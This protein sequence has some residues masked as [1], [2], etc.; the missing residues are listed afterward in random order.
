MGRKR[1]NEGMKIISFVII[2]IFCQLFIGTEW[3]AAEVHHQLQVELDLK[4]GLLKGTD[5]ISLDSSSPATLNLLLSPEAR[6]ISI[7]SAGEEIELSRQGE[8][9]VVKQPG[10]PLKISWI[11]P[12]QKKI[13]AEPTH[14][15]DP[16]YGVVA[17]ISP[18]GSYLAEGSNWYPRVEGQNATHDISVTLPPGHWAV[19]AGQLADREE[20]E[21]ENSIRWTADYPLS[22]LSLASGPWVV[23]EDS[24]NKI[25]VYAF[26]YKDSSAF[27]DTYITSAKE[28]LNLYETLFGPYPFHKFAVVENFLP[29][30]YGFP[31]WT[32]LGSR[33]VKLPFIVQTSLGHEVA[34][35]WWGN[36]VHTDPRYGNW[37]EGLTTYVADYLYKE[38]ES[39]A[40]AKDY[41]LKIL[42]EYS[43]LVPPQGMPLRSFQ[44]RSDKASQAIGYGKSAMV[45]HLI[46]QRIGDQAFWA[47]LR[48]TAHTYM[49]KQ[50][51]WNQLIAEFSHQANSNL[52]PV[53]TPWLDRGDIPRLYLAA[54]KS[55]RLDQGWQI[56]GHLNQT[57]LPYPLL[58][59]VV[60]NTVEGEVKRQL[61]SDQSRTEFRFDL[62]SRPLSL[63]IDPDCQ[64]L[65]RLD[66]QEIPA[67]INALRAAR[68]LQA[69]FSDQLS[70]AQR[71]AAG[72][73]LA[74]L[75]QASVSLDHSFTDAS[76]PVLYVSGFSELPV[77]VNPP[78]LNIDDFGKIS[79][80]GS[81][82][83]RSDSLF[84]V[85][86]NDRGVIRGLFVPG[87][88]LGA[89]STARKIPHYGKYSYLTFHEATNNAKGIWEPTVAPL[90][91]S[92]EGG[93]MN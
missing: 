7:L 30:G 8:H 28:Y 81:Q 56:T 26:F 59:D 23:F 93:V 91:V 11:L 61:Q 78:E 86:N 82:L 25:P 2:F 46:R 35:S 68:G 43:T 72:T 69:V 1:Y 49:F 48:E 6:N 29:T 13:P 85:W 88:D 80:M 83:D 12:G 20:T 77:D 67:T 90:T 40:A 5:T 39:T 50:I 27:A 62:G 14:H 34:H 63:A 18:E 89:E 38:K 70:T 92:F 4:H 84:M 54:V 65:R 21:Q 87:E 42:R 74:G 53:I 58:L 51:N 75:R 60:I 19:T 32:L 17:A 22:G 57:G 24:S 64:L 15:E 31:S 33:V 73:L 3:A 55:S 44:M 36:G 79:F 16:T 41:R 76:S 66:L 37:A 45:F 52:L 47:A 9:L 10:Y 71:K